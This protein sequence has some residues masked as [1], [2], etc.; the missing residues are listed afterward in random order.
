MKTTQHMRKA[1]KST[2]ISSL[3]LVLSAPAFSASDLRQHL[4]VTDS[5]V[6]L[7]DL[8]TDTG[9]FGE[10]IVLEAPAPGKT[11]QISS[12]ELEKM[13]EKYDLE[14]EKPD[15]LKRVR[16]LREGSAVKPDDIQSLLKDH[17]INQGI[18]E[19]I[20]VKIFGYRSGVY[21]PLDADIYDIEVTDLSIGDR[22]DRFS[23]VLK[24]P[25]SHN[26]TKELRITGS[27]DQ[28]ETVPTLA[29][30]IKPGEVIAETDIRWNTISIRR[31]NSRTI[32]NAADLIGQ[33]VKR[34]VRAGKILMTSDIVTPTAIDKG[35]QLTLV[36]KIGAMQLT[37]GARALERGGIG[38]VINVMNSKSRQTVEA[39]IT[40]PGIAVVESANVLKLASR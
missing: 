36:F 30:A 25:V 19:G 9:E 34:P 32:Q 17:L 5:M 10:E 1:L 26:Q 16:L 13:A 3:M 11:I 22:R 14:W 6:K 20:A 2:F 38:E 24:L 29:R 18:D 28:V 33:T 35:E 40:A 21:I 37:A 31:I 8:F 23:A 7:S 15:Y 27:I 12:F 4:S 39:R